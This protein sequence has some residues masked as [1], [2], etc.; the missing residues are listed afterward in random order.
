M[1]VLASDAFTRANETPLASPWVK[2]ISAAGTF[3]L[4]SNH[5]I[6]HADVTDCMAHYT[7]PTWPNDHYAQ[8]VLTGTPGGTET[9]IG[10]AVRCSTAS[11]GSGYWAVVRVTTGGNECYISRWLNG[12]YTNITQRTV[13]WINGDILRLEVQGTTLRVYRSTPLVSGGAFV[14][15]GADITDA[16]IA[17]GAAGIAYSSTMAT[18][19]L[20]T[21]EGG[22]LAAGGG[23]TTKNIRSF[24]LGMALGMGLGIPDV[25]GA[26]MARHR[27]GLYIP[28]RMAA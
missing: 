16:N 5:V 8:A 21:W 13:S 12:S 22:D 4:S 27:S 23:R 25:S 14:Q 15:L 2:T 6:P 20:D 17:S 3:D 7:G 10:V 18:G 28:E 1:S 11:G 24:P 9:G 26:P 19:T